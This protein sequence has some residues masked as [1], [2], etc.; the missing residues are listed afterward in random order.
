[1]QLRSYTDSLSQNTWRKHIASLHALIDEKQVHKV[2]LARKKQLDFSHPPSAWHMI[3]RLKGHALQTTLFVF[4]LAEHTA[5]LGA[6]PERLF[7]R[8]AE[9]VSVDALAGTRRRGST[10]EEDRLLEKQL[11]ADPKEQSEFLSVKD[12]IHGAITPL[13]EN[14]TW[15]D[16]DRV[17]KTAHVQH[18]CNTAT[19]LKKRHITDR[20][21]IDALHPTPAIGGFPQRE[22]LQAINRLES[23]QRGWYSAPVGYISA[24]ETNLVVAIR[25]ALLHNASLHLFAGA[26]IVAASNAEKE[27]EEI[28]H[29]MRLMLH[30]CSL[31]Y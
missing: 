4:A 2:V 5:F 12:F 29:K 1:V 22:A 3:E 11:R 6:S 10:E 7:F 25:S 31:A 30:G 26:G 9:H 16:A 24:Q 28:D 23:F 21:L 8:K 13:A 17:L 19:F 18:L 14:C 27:W 15:L 20:S